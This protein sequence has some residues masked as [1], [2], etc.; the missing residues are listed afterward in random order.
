MFL[1]GG[2]KERAVTQDTVSD[3]PLVVVPESEALEQLFTAEEREEIPKNSLTGQ[4][5][6]YVWKRSASGMVFVAASRK[7]TKEPKVYI[8]AETKKSNGQTAFEWGHK[9]GLGKRDL[10]A[11]AKDIDVLKKGLKAIKQRK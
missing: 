8:G 3:K 4:Q 2:K 1:E 9:V 7:G 6:C 5:P 11:M 10:S